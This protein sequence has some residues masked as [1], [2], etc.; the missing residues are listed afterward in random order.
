[1]FYGLLGGGREAVC[2]DVVSIP[3]DF[4]FS[5][6]QA[7]DNVQKQKWQGTEVSGEKWS[8]ETLYNSAVGFYFYVLDF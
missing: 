7:V 5:S 6:T 3:K 4:N 2:Q 8:G 1:M